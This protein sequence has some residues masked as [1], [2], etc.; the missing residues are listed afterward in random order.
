MLQQI[1]I[2]L[3]L[4]WTIFIRTLVQVPLVYKIIMSLLM[5]GVVVFLS[6]VSLLLTFKVFVVIF[7]THIIICNQVKY[8]REKIIYLQQYKSLLSLSYFIDFVLVSVPF[9]LI[10]ILLGLIT[11]LSSALIAIYR[12]KPIKVNLSLPVSPSLLFIKSGFLW[13]A[14]SRYFLPVAWILIIL[15]ITLAFIHKNFNLAMVAFAG[16]SVFSFFVTIFQTESHEFIQ[17]YISPK[18]FIRRTISE[19]AINSVIFMLI[20]TILMLVFFPQRATST[21]TAFISSLLIALNMIFVK[22]AL[23][24]SLP[25]ALF[26]FVVSLALIGALIISVYGAVLIPFYYILIFYFYRNNI[27]KIISNNET[28]GNQIS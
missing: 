3:K 1:N 2:I 21:L 9:F 25:I 19:T 23:Y 22:Y 6:K 7:F 5:A 16:I 20:P 8:S 14:N 26:V 27:R 11:I 10:N 17:I 18:H 24:P 4:K 12:T 13:H 15:L 28:G